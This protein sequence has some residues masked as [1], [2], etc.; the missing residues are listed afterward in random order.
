MRRSSTSNLWRLHDLPQ[1]RCCRVGCLEPRSRI[2]GSSLEALPVDF[3]HQPALLLRLQPLGR[4]SPPVRARHQPVRQSGD[5]ERGERI[6]RRGVAFR[7]GISCLLSRLMVELASTFKRVI[8]ETPRRIVEFDL[9][10][11]LVIL[12]Y[13]AFCSNDT[14]MACSTTFLGCCERKRNVFY[15]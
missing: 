4:K 7:F 12:I 1:I 14:I 11:A 10:Q 15:S 2:P 9:A 6:K 8:R 3:P 13:T 5:L